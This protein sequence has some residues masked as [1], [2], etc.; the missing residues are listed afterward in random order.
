MADHC[1]VAE[2]TC[3]K[4]KAR[5]YTT[6]REQYF[7]IGAVPPRVRWTVTFQVNKIVKG[8]FAE[9]TIAIVDARVAGNPYALYRFKVGTIYTVGFNS[10]SDNT[11]R[12]FAVFGQEADLFYHDAE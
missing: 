1:I 3:L 6:F 7:S 12:G 8:N 4:A 2:V 5:E 9:Q 11:V 10:I